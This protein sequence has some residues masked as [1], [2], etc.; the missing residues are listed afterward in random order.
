L[1]QFVFNVQRI[2]LKPIL[3]Y[4]MSK[5]SPFLQLKS[6]LIHGHILDIDITSTSKEQVLRIFRSSLDKF[7]VPGQIASKI[8]VVTPNPELI[9]LC[10][11]DLVLREVV[12][13]A[14]FAPPD[15]VGL[16]FAWKALGL[17]GTPKLIKGRELFK[18]LVE[19][20]NKKSWRVFLLGDK[21]ALKTKEV[22]LRS[23]KNIIIEAEE[24]PWL[25]KE[26][27]PLS[28]E[29]KVKEEK[30]VAQINRFKPQ[31]LFV[32]FG[33]PK[34]EKWV[35]KWLPRLDAGS[36]M[37]VGGTFDYFAGK[38]ALPPEFLEK[39]GL[40]WL[41]RL[42]RQPWRAPRILSAVVVFPFRVLASKIG[43]K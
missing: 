28:S 43:Q 31:M 5:K 9:N 34:Q 8:F 26:A 25:D 18:S 1:N 4:L 24:G 2:G 16:V 3:I 11:R 7:F 32:G 42:I 30:V 23:F 19:L 39:V 36:A 35:Y 33:V 20:A 21:T 40:E 29:D 22:L 37:V 38:A 41:W 10:Q 13:S 14:T 17:P 12:N 27:N 15:G 6:A